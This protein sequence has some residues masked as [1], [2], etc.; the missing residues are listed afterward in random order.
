MNTTTTIG[1]MPTTTMVHANPLENAIYR[2]PQTIEKSATVAPF[3][4]PSPFPPDQNPANI[5]IRSLA[6]TSRRGMLAA[7]N[8]IANRL[9]VGEFDAYTFP[10]HEVRFSHASAIAAELWAAHAPAYAA[11]QLAA[12]RGALRMAWQLGQMTAEDY[13]RAIAIKLP[14][15]S[16]GD[17]LTGRALEYSEIDK[18]FASID[19]DHRKIARRDAALLALL[20]ATGLRRSEAANL[21]AQDVDWDAQSLK[22]LHGKGNKQR[23]VPIA[24]AAF[25]RLTDWMKVRG[26]H[27]GPVFCCHLSARKFEN[28]AMTDQNILIILR[29][30]A[31]AAGVSS[32]TAHDLRR[33]CATHLIEAGE[34]LNAIR[35]VLGHSSIA[36]T[37]AYDRSGEVAKRRA[38][39]ALKIPSRIVE[40]KA[41]QS[42]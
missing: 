29:K 27:D 10:W 36:Q 24:D 5:Y 35:S 1:S 16:R 37:A 14:K 31:K 39:N 33:S 25:E 2:V 42:A 30:R 17:T 4:Q 28:V 12:L 13:Q 11:K 40:P 6:P 8:T 3:S 32:F 26:P 34:N 9:S 41:V 20:F 15:Y 38:V 18:L 7:L 19:A 23:E 21:N 22:V